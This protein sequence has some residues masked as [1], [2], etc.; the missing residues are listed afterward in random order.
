MTAASPFVPGVEVGHATAYGGRSGCT[1]VLGPFRA[2]AEV[3][4]LATGSREL[5]VLRS[6][7]LVPR[8]DAILLAGGSAFGLAA[9]D[10]VVSWLAERGRGH[11]AGVAR[12]PIV[13]AAVI[14][15][16][17]QHQTRPDAETGREACVD[18]R[19]GRP[20]EGMVG[21]GCGATVGKIAGPDGAMDG[22]VGVASAEVDGFQVGAL[23]VVNA[24]GDVLDGAGRI[25]AGARGADGTFVDTAALLRRGGSRGELAAVTAGANTTLAVVATD[26][27]LT[28]VGLGRLARMAGNA[29]PR[30]ISP[31]HTPFDGD[32]VFV[33]STSEAEREME[34]GE[35]MALGAT[36]QHALE[37]AITRAVTEGHREQHR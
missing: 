23:V 21:A 5:D 2:A 20:A 3:R 18:A 26:A 34:S 16:L 10:G 4:G 24:L 33:V 9:A 27:P 13:P 37:E 19:A 7:H 22:G 8:V 1:V 14:F 29:L 6:D 28:R 11:D 31:V 32:V 25:V 36:A 12:V 30:R 17:H 35:V 15:D